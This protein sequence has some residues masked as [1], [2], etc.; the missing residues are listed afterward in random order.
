MNRSHWLIVGVTMLLNQASFASEFNITVT[1]IDITK[2]GNI[3]V[4]IY[5]EQGFPKIHEMSLLSETKKATN[6]TMNFTFDINEQE[7]AIKVLHD[8]NSD[9]KVTKNWTGIYPKDGLGFSNKQKLTFTGPPTYE[10]S[11][12][13]VIPGKNDVTI[14]IIY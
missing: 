10:K 1:N 6:K 7:L 12:I 3:T 14:S 5:G 11:K 13:M 4:M 9:G 2:A 8:E